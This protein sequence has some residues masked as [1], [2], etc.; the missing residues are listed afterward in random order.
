MLHSLIVTGASGAGKTAT[1][2]ALAARNI[3]GVQCFHFDSIGV[4]SPGA[5]ER[6]HGSGERWQAW[7]TGEWLARLGD[8]PTEVRVAVLDGQT[9][10]Q[11]AFDAAGRA[12]RRTH[13]V[14]FDCSAEVRDARL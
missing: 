9:R 1:V 5:M 13:V 2:R 4:P 8:L 11:F 7:A 6:E 3:P 12:P 10:P 14:L